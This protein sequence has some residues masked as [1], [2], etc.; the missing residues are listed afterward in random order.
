MM[1]GARQV[2]LSRIIAERKFVDFLDFIST[3]LRELNDF[4]APSSSP[5]PSNFL[6]TLS[7]KTRKHYK[8]RKKSGHA[9]SPH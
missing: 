4:L 5:P 2:I 3:L 1:R 6:P 8:K 9:Q 7:S